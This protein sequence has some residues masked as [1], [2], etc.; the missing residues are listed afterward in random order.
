MACP[1]MKSSQSSLTVSVA[2]LVVSHY[3][4]KFLSYYRNFHFLFIPVSHLWLVPS[5][6]NVKVRGWFLI[7][8]FF[9]E[10]KESICG[11]L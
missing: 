10:L 6:L 8:Y 3:L 7:F 9:M 1:Q 5:I 2:L 4:L 11:S